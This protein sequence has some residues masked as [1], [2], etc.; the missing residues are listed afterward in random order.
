MKDH[1]PAKTSCENKGLDLASVHMMEEVAFIEE[2][3]EVLGFPAL[4]GSNF[5]LTWIGRFESP[6]QWY[7]GSALDFAHYVEGGNP[8]GDA[9]GGNGGELCVTITSNG[10][11]WDD[12]DCGGH[13]HPYLCAEPP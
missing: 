6:V 11:T 4:P 9:V 1:Y 8:S 13:L 5:G 10:R 3:I 7:D 12:E 2:T